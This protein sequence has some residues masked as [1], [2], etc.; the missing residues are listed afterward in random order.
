MICLTLSL[1]SAGLLVI[2]I[3]FY[4]FISRYE[5][6]LLTERFGDEYREY[7]RK[8]PMLFPIR[9]RRET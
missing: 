8:V 7:M 5:E 1:A 9:F 6:K 2:I 3:A 4:R